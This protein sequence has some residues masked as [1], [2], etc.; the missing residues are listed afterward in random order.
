MDILNMYSKYAYDTSVILFKTYINSW[1]VFWVVLKIINRCLFYPE[2]P[3]EIIDFR[4]YQ[5]QIVFAEWA[6]AAQIEP[7]VIEL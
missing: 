1:L 4:V 7:L 6:P 5:Q 2:Q 3:L